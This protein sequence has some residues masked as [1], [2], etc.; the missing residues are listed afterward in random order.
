MLV[1]DEQDKITNL[2]WSFLVRLLVTF[3]DPDW[4]KIDLRQKQLTTQ[5]SISK[6]ELLKMLFT[7]C[8]YIYTFI[9]M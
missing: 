5:L 8:I 7:I 9:Y 3:T 2:S 1:A 6:H 4:V